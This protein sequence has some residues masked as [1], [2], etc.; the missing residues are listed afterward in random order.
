MSFGTSFQICW[1]AVPNPEGSTF[2]ESSSFKTVSKIF[3]YYSDESS[4]DVS[5]K[6]MYF[7]KSV[8]NSRKEIHVIVLRKT[9]TFAHANLAYFPY[10]VNFSNSF[11]AWFKVYKTTIF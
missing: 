5:D 7:K 9:F 4:T 6:K 2:F 1:V 3:E 11:T 10:G 8:T